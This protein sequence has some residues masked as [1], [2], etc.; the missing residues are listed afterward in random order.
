MVK[1]IFSRWVKFTDRN[2]LENINYPGVYCIAIT[3][4]NL[5]S[6][7]FDL[8]EDIKYVGMT[9]SINGLKGRLYQ[10]DNTIKGKRGHGGADRFRF[11]HKDYLS[12][13]KM[14]YVSV[15]P[16]KC[17]VTTNKPYDLRIMGEVAQ[18]E[19]E[20]LARYVEKYGQLPEFNDKKL[21]LK[22]SKRR[23][24]I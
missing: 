4:K 2:S 14:L 5:S 16:F 22:D 12:L 20:Y 15:N 11:K 13:V 8:I 18:F 9:N 17:N 24:V 6:K 10:F 1:R 3:D 21:S 23:L 19:Y 7:E